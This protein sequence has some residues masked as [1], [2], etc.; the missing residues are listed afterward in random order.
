[1]AT[2]TPDLLANIEAVL[3]QCHELAAAAGKHILCTDINTVLQ[4]SRQVVFVEQK[5]IENDALF[6][7]QMKAAGVPN[8]IHHITNTGI[9]ST[10]SSLATLCNVRAREQTAGSSEPLH[11]GS[12]GIPWI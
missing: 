3:R 6:N 5:S 4:C 9:T 1:M 7:D 8:N 2:F 11:S 10:G 12:S